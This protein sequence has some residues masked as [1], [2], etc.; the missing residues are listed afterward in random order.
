MSWFPRAGF[1]KLVLKERI[2]LVSDPAEVSSN[3]CTGEVDLRW[4]R[5]IQCFTGGERS[6]ESSVVKMVSG[7]TFNQGTLHP[8]KAKSI[9]AFASPLLS[10]HVN[11][12]SMYMY[13]LSYVCIN[14]YQF[15]YKS[16]YVCVYIFLLDFIW[17]QLIINSVG[18][19]NLVLMLLWSTLRCFGRIECRRFWC[20][21]SS[22]CKKS[23]I[24]G[25]Q[26]IVRNGSHSASLLRAEMLQ[27]RRVALHKKDTWRI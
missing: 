27:K 15:I 1:Q 26:S 9:F 4:H 3:V 18:W 17:Y 23:T 19:V 16:I 24:R 14:T 20:C 13:E 7:H 5:R 6:F 22:K 25:V 11:L 10:S 2:R 21:N 8:A 12:K